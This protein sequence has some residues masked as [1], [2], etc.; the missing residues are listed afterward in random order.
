MWDV[1]VGN[2]ISA[3]PLLKHHW[4]LHVILLTENLDQGDYLFWIT[5]GHKDTDKPGEITD[6][7]K[8]DLPSYKHLFSFLSEG[9]LQYFKDKCFTEYGWEKSL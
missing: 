1:W 6:Y 9:S 5:F 4:L 2:H 7:K 8:V 3:S